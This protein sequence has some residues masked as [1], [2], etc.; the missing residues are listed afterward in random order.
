MVILCLTRG[1]GLGVGAKT[2]NKRLRDGNSHD[3][4]SFI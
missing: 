4:G 2:A 1:G 3:R